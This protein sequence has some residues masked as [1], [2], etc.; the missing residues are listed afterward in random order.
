MTIPILT[1]DR[2]L[3]RPFKEEDAA[4]FFELF[5]DPSVA[6]FVIYH[7]LN[8][9]E[10]AKQMLQKQ[11]LDT[12]KALTSF[13][14]AI[15]LKSDTKPIGYVN[16]HQS[17][18]YDL[19]YGLHKKYW[20]KGII[21]EAAQMV[22]QRAKAEGIPYLTATHDILNPYSGEVMKKLGMQYQYSY[23]E[24]WKPNVMVTFRMYQ[25]NFTVAPS[26]VYQKYWNQYPHMIEDLPKT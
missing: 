2:L 4:A 3:L 16:I 11:Y 15:C 10:E 26:F 9:I 5:S 22:V 21:S 23:V 8:S 25:I 14:Y 7:P 17:D 24:E 18:S 1:S 13:H 12:Y 6:R 20:H 19:G